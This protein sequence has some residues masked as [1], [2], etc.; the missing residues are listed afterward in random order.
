[1]PKSRACANS[2]ALSRRNL[3]TGMTASG[4]SVALASDVSASSIGDSDLSPLIERVMSSVVPS[5]GGF[6]FVQADS[7]QALCE[8]SGVKWGSHWATRKEL[9]SEKGA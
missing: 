4:L 2:P 7:L 1:M 9:V 5:R 6:V 3:M 8:A